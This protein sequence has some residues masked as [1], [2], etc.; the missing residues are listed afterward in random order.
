MQIRRRIFSNDPD[1]RASLYDFLFGADRSV[2]PRQS[3]Q[4]VVLV[5]VRRWYNRA[6]LPLRF[7]CM[8]EKAEGLSR[9]LKFPYSS[10]TSFDFPEQGARARGL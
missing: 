10:S 9:G 5:H 8:G 7:R 1:D 3:R 2:R 4:V 6:D